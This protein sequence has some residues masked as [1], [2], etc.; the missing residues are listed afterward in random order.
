MSRKSVI[1]PGNF[2]STKLSTT[3]LR[4]KGDRLEALLLHDNKVVYSETPYM[5]APFGVSSFEKGNTGKFDWSI[6]LS[7][8]VKNKNSE[9]ETTDMNDYIENM[10]GLD[11][12]MIEFGIKNSK[13]IFGEVYDESQRGIVNALYS[14]TVKIKTDENGDEYPP[15]LTPK[16]MKDYDNE[17]VPSVDIY[18]KNRT[19]INIETFEDL[20][21]KVPKRSFVKAI[22]Q[23]RIW[24]LGGKFG[25]SWK[26][27]QLL[28]DPSNIIG[29]PTDF[30]FSEEDD[31]TTE[32]T[33]K[34]ETK[35]VDSDTEKQDDDDDEE[36][37][38][39]EDEEDDDEEEESIAS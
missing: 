32:S 3:T 16:I 8:M 23:P 25:I 30:A 28:V 21:T 38:E 39:E 14:K 9:K 12:F 27:V 31:A 1:K 35:A 10:K 29:K 2:N 11:K 15:K 5:S 36:E 34:T 26:V 18:L 22:I 20:Q 7:S 13:Q 24:F 6:N 37:E 17:D 19:K 4:K 33:P